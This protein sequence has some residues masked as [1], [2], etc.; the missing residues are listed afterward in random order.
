[1]AAPIEERVYQVDDDRL[2]D[3]SC[4][5]VT[6]FEQVAKEDIEEKLGVK[7]DVDG[8]GNVSFCLPFGRVLEVG[9]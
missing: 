3:L 9:L 8:R 4:T 7:V 6:G 1:M 5:V 2:C